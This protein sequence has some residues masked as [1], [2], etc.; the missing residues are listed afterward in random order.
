ME[1]QIANY[2]ARLLVE[3]KP[4]LGKAAE[5]YRLATIRCNNNASKLL[6][7]TSSSRIV[8]CIDLAATLFDESVDKALAAK[9]AGT[10][11]KVYNTMYKT[12][13]V[14]LNASKPCSVKELA[15]FAN[16]IGN[17]E[18]LAEKLLDRFA[19]DV[20]SKCANGNNNCID[21]TKP[22]FPA[23]ALCVACRH[24]KVRVSKDKLYSKA[25]ISKGMFSN[26]CESLTACLRQIEDRTENRAL[27]KSEVKSDDESDDNQISYNLWKEK[28]LSKPD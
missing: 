18:L 15:V 23:A 1:K 2:G 20:N 13:E 7:A 8:I 28:I 9:L 24:L 4:V 10:S 19:V 14:L 22:Q 21:I 16:C 11:R 27:H 25:S 12:Y 3:N 5:F 17:A 6:P 26:L